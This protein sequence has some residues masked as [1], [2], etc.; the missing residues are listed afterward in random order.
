MITKVTFKSLIA[1]TILIVFLQLVYDVTVAAPAN[2]SAGFAR[3]D[4]S[5]SSAKKIRDL[6]HA[7]YN[8]RG[9]AS[10]VSFNSEEIQENT[11][12]F[13]AV[14][15]TK[16]NT[17]NLLAQSL[18][19]E[20]FVEEPVWESAVQMDSVDPNDREI[21]TYDPD[22]GVGIPFRPDAY[23][24][25]LTAK[26]RAVFIDSLSASAAQKNTEVIRRVNYLR[27]DSSFERP[28]GNFRER[29]T[30]GGRLGDIVHSTP[31]FVGGPNRLGRNGEPYPQ[32]ADSYAT[33]AADSDNA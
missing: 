11:L 7:A 3:G 4:P 17:G 6:R 9:A 18:T 31:V 1:Q 15:N 33:F 26:Q 2:F 32:D 19:D 27:G 21:F 20:G 24:L 23:P 22:L 13:R 25:G 5:S 16:I 29:P 30:V 8:C 10:A 28:V 14:N 12:I